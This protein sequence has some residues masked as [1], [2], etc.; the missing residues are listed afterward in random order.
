MRCRKGGEG[1]GRGLSR[2]C[3]AM[4]WQK[5]ARGE[6]KGK[7]GGP[8]VEKQVFCLRLFSS[9][10]FSTIRVCVEMV[11]ERCIVYSPEGFFFFFFFF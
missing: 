11:G 9:S 3:H 4:S 6:E 1:I 5:A 10:S 2:S 7:K 8:M